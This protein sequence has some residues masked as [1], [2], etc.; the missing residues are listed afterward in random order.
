MATTASP[1]P[2][3][4]EAPPSKPGPKLIIVGAL[5]GLALGAITGAFVIAPRMDAT[6]VEAHA[7]VAE[8]HGP[9]A[10]A[11]PATVHLI[12][13]LVVNPANTNGQRFLLVTTALVVKDAAALEELAA[14]DAEVRD[15]IVDLLS[16]R[17]IDELGD[18][19][20]REALK[21]DLAA[22]IG[23]LFKE[24]VVK[25]VLLPQFVIQ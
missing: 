19:S 8:D 10:A 22:A 17:T 3:S 2:V 12:E 25:R 13:N 7:E 20:R 23:A 9:A 21:G 14:R 1:A 4:A 16:G 6:P 5:A 15:R 11:T 24:G 18:P